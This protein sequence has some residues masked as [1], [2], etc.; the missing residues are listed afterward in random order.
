MNSFAELGE[1]VRSGER[2]WKQ[3]GDVRA[4][5]WDGLVLF[6]YTFK[7]EI[8]NRWNWFE[9][10]SRG[11]I[12]DEKTGN[13]V[14]LCMRKFWNYLQGGRVPSGY[15][16]D[17][18]EKLDGCFLGNTKLNLWD[19]GT[20]SIRKIVNEKLPAI[21]IGMDDEGNIVPTRVVDW[22]RNGPKDEEGD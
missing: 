8:E 19:G 4:V 2:D 6:N 15:M 22:F 1:L 17:V 7:A 20:I 13:L 10:V 21:L 5:Y 11:L 18:T 12:L 16:I 9:R 3:Y 14:A